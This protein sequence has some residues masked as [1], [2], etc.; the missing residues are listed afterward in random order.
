MS[1]PVDWPQ[2]AEL[3]ARVGVAFLVLIAAFVAG[4][5]LGRV[6]TALLGTARLAPTHQAF[7]RNLV[8]LT[9]GLVGFGIALEVVGLG[10]VATGL[11]AGGGMAAIA[12]GFAFRGVGENLLAGLFLAFSRPFNLGDLIS[13]AGHEG[14]V[15]AISLRHTHIRTSAGADIFLPNA[16]IFGE[17]LTNYTKDGLR[18]PS[19]R[20]G[21]DYRDDLAEACRILE[22]AVAGI[23]G[24]LA[25]PTPVAIVWNF[26]PA[27]AEIEVSFWINT[28]AGTDF[29]LLRGAAMERSRR[30]LLEHDFTLSGDVAMRVTLAG[31]ADPG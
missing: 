17:P 6:A 10:G 15:T 5:V 11:L 29:A 25:E 8:A 16:V 18:R 12:L 2:I 22:S 26:E 31:K 27:Y 4:R 24:V 28:L 20:I 1:L 21:V 3:L 30:V 9:A 14:V 13:C 19:F 7:F 23:P